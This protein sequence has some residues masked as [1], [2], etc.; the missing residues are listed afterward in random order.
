MTLPDM[1]DFFSSSIRIG[2]LWDC[3]LSVA[4]LLI[5]LLI[6]CSYNKSLASLFICLVFLF[7]KK[8]PNIYAL[9]LYPPATLIISLKVDS[10][11]IEYSPGAL[12]APSMVTVPY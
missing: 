10:E 8:P 9:S 7:S 2:R 6:Y 5:R 11:D 12:I 3:E 1:I 4:G